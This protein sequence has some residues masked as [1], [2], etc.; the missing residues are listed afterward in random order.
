MG[1]WHSEDLAA[2]WDATLGQGPP[3]R[4]EQQ[5]ILLALLSAAEIGDG[6]VL[7]LGV[8]SGLVAEAVLDALP[9]VH[10]LGVDISEAMLD[11]AQRRLERFGRRV[12]LQQ[13]DLARVDSIELPAGRYP[14]AFSVQT[15]HHLTDPEKQAATTWVA[16]VL[17]PGGLWVIIDRVAVPEP[18]FADW[19]AVWRLLGA[20]TAGTYAEYLDELEREGDRPA[21]LEDQMRWM[22][23]AG[24][25]VSCLHAYGNRVVLVGRKPRHTS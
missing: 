22:I 1:L 16:T 17:K 12:R 11:L 10:L 5:Q 20:E 18:L 14:A 15:L 21:P 13:H 23:E 7:D 3:T 4:T 19:A 9:R 25:A 2:R 8:G 6:G 24:L